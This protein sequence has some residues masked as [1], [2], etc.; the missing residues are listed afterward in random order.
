MKKFFFYVGIALF[1]IFCFVLTSIMTKSMLYTEHLEIIK[2]TVVNEDSADVQL[3]RD[4]SVIA[5]VGDVMLARNVENLMLTHGPK[6]PFSGLVFSSST[7]DYL[8]G[9]FEAS[10]PI[11]HEMTPSGS[12]RFSVRP[13]LA[14]ILDEVGFTHLSLAN[15][16]ALD[17]GNNGY[18][19]TK[20]VLSANNLKV[21]GHPALVSSSSVTYLKLGSTT[22]ALFGLHTLFS[23]ISDED[24]TDIFREAKQSSDIQIAYVHWGD[25]YV[26]IPNREQEKL[27][28][29]LVD[30]G[31]DLIVGHHPHIVQKLDL[32]KAVPVF[33]SLGNFVFDQ[34]FSN[35]VREGLVLLAYVKDKKLDKVELLPVT[36][37][38]KRSVPTR[39][40]REDEE[41]F[42]TDLTTYSSTTLKKAIM[43]KV[44]Y[45]SH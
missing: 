15:N 14:D 23:G 1:V 31:V 19:N 39:Y 27:A 3:E 17:F 11:V 32:I 18:Q 37:K 35:E 25:E 44:I 6:Y 4:K 34:Y 29:K 33:Y 12:F 43:D 41:K 30:L 13:E 20:A 2:K 7:Y 36:S 26:R 38:D 16:H 9:N 24:L 40:L 42:L 45:L 22:V 28:Q 5:F 21:F 8:V 10:I